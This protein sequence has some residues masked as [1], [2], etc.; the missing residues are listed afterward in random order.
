MKKQDNSIHIGNSN[1]IRGSIISTDS[2]V[3]VHDTDKKVK[4]YSRLLW[5]LLIPIVVIVAGAA[6]C[7]WLGL[8]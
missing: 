4:W 3:T 8:D 6:I 1:R 7:L 5:E 2:C